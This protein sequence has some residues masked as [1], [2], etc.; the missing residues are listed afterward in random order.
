MDLM[1]KEKKVENIE[2]KEE[3][4]TETEFDAESLKLIDEYKRQTGCSFNEA[5][6]KLLEA[7]LENKCIHKAF[8]RIYKTIREEQI[9]MEKEIEEK[10]KKQRYKK[11]IHESNRNPS[12]KPNE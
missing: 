5:V 7:E 11:N 3:A 2:V 1:N 9:I 8:E 6:T 12:I 4:D 10:R